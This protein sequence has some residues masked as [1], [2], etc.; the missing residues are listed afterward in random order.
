MFNTVSLSNEYSVAYQKSVKVLIL[1]KTKDIVEIL[2]VITT[3][4]PCYKFT[5]LEEGNLCSNKASV[6]KVQFLEDVLLVELL[7]LHSS[8]TCTGLFT[9]LP[10]FCE[11]FQHFGCQWVNSSLCTIRIVIK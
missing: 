11:D 10:S 7:V 3:V 1:R 5:Y 2:I 8:I 6:A 4:I 9:V